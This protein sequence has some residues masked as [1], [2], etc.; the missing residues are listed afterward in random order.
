MKCG[1]V[2]TETP[3]EPG[4]VSGATPQQIGLLIGAG[5]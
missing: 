2:P 5:H 4:R 3:S 1:L